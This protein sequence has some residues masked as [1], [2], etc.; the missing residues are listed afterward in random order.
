MPFTYNPEIFSVGDV[1][2]AK[3]IILTAE[4][5][6]TDARWG[7]ETPY[8]SAL[9]ASQQKITADTVVLDHAIGQAGA[10]VRAVLVDYAEI[11]AAVAVDHDFL[12]QN[13]DLMRPEGVPKQI[14]DTADRLPVVPHERAHGG[15]GSYPGQ[16]FVVFD[17]QHGWFLLCSGIAE[18]SDWRI[19]N[20]PI[21]D[22]DARTFSDSFCGYRF[23]DV[24]LEV[25][26]YFCVHAFEFS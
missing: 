6:T 3:A 12:A 23:A 16:E 17:A 11:A 25:C 15:A 10:A 14:V 1:Q 21:G 13:L 5:S 19:Y 22:N 4:N 26:Q 18:L 24:P 20:T 7:Q 9:I 8:L 2:D